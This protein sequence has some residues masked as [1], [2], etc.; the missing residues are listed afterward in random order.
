MKLGVIGSGTMGYG[1]AQA[2]AQK[3]YEV[4]L[5]DIMQDQLD[6]AKN[7]I[8]ASLKGRVAK[9]KI[10]QEEMDSVIGNITTSTDIQKLADREIIIEA[11]I[12]KV[13]LK[14]S[15]FSDIEKIVSKDTLLATNTSSLS[16]IEIAQG[17]KDPSRLIGIHFF[18]PAPVMKLVEIVRSL[19]VREDVVERAKQFAASLDK[20]VILS[21]DTP[22]F[23]VNYLQY[24]FRLNAIRMLEQ[25]MATKE[26]ID[27]AA[28]LGLGHPMGPFELQDLVGLDVTYNAVKAI[29]EETKDP[30]MAPPVLLKRMVEAGLLG[31][32]TGKG[33]YEYPKDK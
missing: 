15:V 26:D 14:Q 27:K 9:G 1:I 8:A 7:S 22:G 33:F 5:Y 29:Y 32:K 23:V 3:G 10:S 18:N 30:A 4:L 11:I 20:E 13:E 17:L 24:P 25:G 6:K 16:I 12:E 28:K 21:K 31:R 19:V 2:A